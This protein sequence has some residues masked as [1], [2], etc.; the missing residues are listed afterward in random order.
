MR[1]EPDADYIMCSRKPFCCTILEFE[2]T[3]KGKKKGGVRTPGSEKRNRL[4][5]GHDQQYLDLLA[6]N[7][8]RGEHP[9][10]LRAE[11]THSEA[12]WLIHLI[13]MAVPFCNCLPVHAATTEEASG[14]S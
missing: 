7:V 13:H 14:N 1:R 3:N 12:S 9:A 4:H 2:R 6:D 11:N 5:F 10:N 8:F